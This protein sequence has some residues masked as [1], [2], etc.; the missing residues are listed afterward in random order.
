MIAS[1]CLILI[2]SPVLAIQMNIARRSLA[3]QISAGRVCHK[4]TY[5]GGLLDL[6]CRFFSIDWCV[7]FVRLVGLSIC[8]VVCR[9]WHCCS[10]GFGNRFVVVSV[11]GA[12]CALVCCGLV[13]LVFVQSRLLCPL[14][15]VNLYIEG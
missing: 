9:F 7:S 13:C 5:C 11:V 3:M 1:S 2:F 15:S 4:I 14:T 12:V 8:L 6:V 10:A